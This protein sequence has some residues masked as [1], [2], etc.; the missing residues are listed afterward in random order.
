MTIIQELEDV[1]AQCDRLGLYGSVQRLDRVIR[2][3]AK[4]SRRHQPHNTKPVVV[5]YNTPHGAIA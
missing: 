5:R 3:L 1:R 4:Q 2:H